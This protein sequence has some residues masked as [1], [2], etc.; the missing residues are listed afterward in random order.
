MSRED[1]YEALGMNLEVLS[2]FHHFWLLGVCIVALVLVPY[3]V[4]KTVLMRK[5][6]SPW[7]RS[8]S[9]AL[10]RGCL[11]LILSYMSTLAVTESS[12]VDSLIVDLTK[13]TE[14]N[15]CL[16][17]YTLALSGRSLKRLR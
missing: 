5:E 2:E 9:P 1:A 10:S 3:T 6:D 7:L 15:V 12:E 8:L 11:V 13:V 16:D 4:F 17:D 14:E